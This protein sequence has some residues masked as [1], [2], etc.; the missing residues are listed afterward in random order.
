MKLKLTDIIKYTCIFVFI[1]L[2]YIY[3]NVLMLP[4]TWI[5]FDFDRN[6]DLSNIFY[7]LI[8]LFLTIIPYCYYFRKDHP[9]TF[10]STLLFC[11]YIIPSNCTM[12]LSGYDFIYY[13]S[14]NLFNILLLYFL[15]KESSRSNSNISS[16]H[17]NQ[18]NYINSPR[19]QKN[20]RIFTIFTCIGV[21][22]YVYYFRGSLSLSGI[23][24]DDI[25]DRRANVAD[26]YLQ[27]TDGLIAYVMTFWSAFYSSMLIIGL[28]ISLRNNRKIDVLLCLF[29]YLVLFSFNTQKTVLFKPIIAIFIYYIVK[30]NRIKNA[31][32]LFLLGYSALLVFS[33]IEYYLK[34][35]SIV[36]SVII[37]RID[38]MPQYLSHAYY[39]FF[40]IN[41]KIWLTRDFFQLEKLVRFF[42]PG[43]YAHGAV[44]VI[45]DNCFPGVPS[46]NTGL[47]AEAYAQLGYLGVFVFPPIIAKLLGLLNKY[48]QWYGMGAAHV[49]MASLLISIINIQILA[50]RGILIFVVFILITW[51]IKRSS[52]TSQ[53]KLKI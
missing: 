49:L 16:N 44:A 3:L 28:Y 36:Y 4:E 40:S 43:S 30:T 27:N 33:F 20:I 21:I 10:I 38:Y 23:F 12:T 6:I 2:A 51:I 17:N 37:R 48:A 39:E 5:S 47:F 52:Q 7:E 42:Y 18:F 25:Y 14:L 22:L 46:P 53:H 50:T 41:N 32:M 19:L 1:K 8:F 11:L 35:E 9:L 31:N 34:Q 26:L 24:N 45:A 29:T 15:G 13:F